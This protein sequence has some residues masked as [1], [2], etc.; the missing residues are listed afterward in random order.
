MKST[1]SRCHLVNG[2]RLKCV[3]A[4]DKESTQSPSRSCTKNGEK[5]DVIEGLPVEAPGA[6]DLH[7]DLITVSSDVA[8]SNGRDLSRF[9]QSGSTAWT[10]RDGPISIGRATPADDVE[11]S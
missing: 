2:H 5:V 1:T 11:P 6:S 8:S 4:V 7:R 9:W 10:H 3:D